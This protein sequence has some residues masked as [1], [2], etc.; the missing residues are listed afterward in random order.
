ME[1][2]QLMNLNSFS[3]IIQ[4][5]VVTEAYLIPQISPLIKP[6]TKLSE[7]KFFLNN[8]SLINNLKFQKMN[9]YYK[10]YPPKL[11][12]YLNYLNIFLIILFQFEMFS[13]FLMN[14]SSPINRN[15]NYLWTT[16]NFWY[17]INEFHR[18][19]FHFYQSFF[20]TF[21]KNFQ[22]ILILFINYLIIIFIYNLLNLIFLIPLF[23]Y[24]CLFHLFFSDPNLKIDRY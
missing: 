22:L 6:L 24:L 4:S 7:I 13:N 21:Q 5:Q 18:F 17:F 23:N 16:L 12:Y 19:N 11:K 14:L 1:I 2:N 3:C 9:H 15:L 8:F 20:M 10:F